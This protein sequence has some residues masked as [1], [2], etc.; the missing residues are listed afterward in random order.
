LKTK[1]KIIAF[2][3]EFLTTYSSPKNLTNSADFDVFIKSLPEG[4]FDIFQKTILK[5]FFENADDSSKHQILNLILREKGAAFDLDAFYSKMANIP[6]V[7]IKTQ[8]TN[9]FGEEFAQIENVVT[10]ITTKIRNKK[11]KVVNPSWGTNPENFS[12]LKLNNLWDNP[13]YKDAAINIFRSRE[14][15]IKKLKDELTSYMIGFEDQFQDLAKNPE[16]QQKLIAAYA[17][18]VKNLFL[19][20]KFFEGE[21]IGDFKRLI[22]NDKTIAKEIKDYFKGQEVTTNSKSKI[23][24]D[25]LNQKGILKEVLLEPL[26]D[27]GR[28]LLP[29]KGFA[30]AFIENAMG[31]ANFKEKFGTTVKSVITNSSFWQ[32]V[33]YGNK[34][35][36]QREINN[37][38]RAF[39]GDNPNRFASTAK[40]VVA[41][42]VTNIAYEGGVVLALA[43][44]RYFGNSFLLSDYGGGV[45]AQQSW[46]SKFLITDKGINRFTGLSEADYENL[47]KE[48]EGKGGVNLAEMCFKETI[49]VRTNGLTNADY[50]VKGIIMAT[51]FLGTAHTIL[52]N[53]PLGKLLVF[54][55]N[56]SNRH[57]DFRNETA[58]KN[59]YD[60]IYK[61]IASWFGGGSQIPRPNRTDTSNTTDTSNNLKYRNSG[62]DAIIIQKPTTEIES[63]KIGNQSLSFAPAGSNATYIYV[64]DQS[65]ASSVKV[66]GKDRKIYNLTLQ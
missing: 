15:Y 46:L 38:I 36:L 42:F 43:L 51:P 30:K 27:V 1:D 66:T 18:T 7:D 20:L 8:I 34:N 35:Y 17:A 63:A 58:Y 33:K 47:L 11:K 12:I 61:S 64:D 45:Y 54:I 60:L 26:R 10:Y 32:V 2:E 22:E 16:G 21:I 53:S 13:N 5:E 19:K 57:K 49:K 39:K 48:Y 9:N 50:L 56:N 24:F 25:S 55:I 44:A 29:S 23:L 14:N 52:T 65:R 4:L 59:L 6:E 3:D 28:S 40:F 62:M 41:T 31:Q 37:Y